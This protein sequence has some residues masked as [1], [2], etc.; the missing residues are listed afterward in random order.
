MNKTLPGLKSKTSHTMQEIKNLRLNGK[1][2]VKLFS[3]SHKEFGTIRF[4]L[5]CV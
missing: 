5:V 1:V 4:A 2:G 3:K